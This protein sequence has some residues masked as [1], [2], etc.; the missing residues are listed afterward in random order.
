M[1]RWLVVGAGSAGC[2]VA[3]I[4][5]GHADVVL[6]EAGPDHG[7]D[8]TPD[9]GGP[10][11]DDPVRLRPDVM[12]RRR[13]GRTVEP[14]AQGFGIGGSGLVNGAIAVPGGPETGETRGHLLP[15][16]APRGRGR[17]AD[18]LRRATPDA[19]ELL[20]VR[21]DGRRVTTA[22]VYLDPVRD[23]VDVRARTSVERVLLDDG[24]AIGVAT[25]TG[26][27]IEADVVVVCSGAI[28]TPAL[29]LRSGVRTA[30]VGEGLQDQPAV[31]VTV[32][33]T[34]P[35]SPSDST[36]SVAVERTG[37]EILALERLTAGDG[38]GALM[39]GVTVV[40]ASGSV[41]VV[42]G[43]TQVDLGQLTEPVDVDR[44]LRATREAIELCRSPELGEV[45]AGA[46]LDD[47]GTPI[48]VVADDA[49]L[50]AWILDHH[51]GY[52]HVAGSCRMGVVTDRRGWVRGHHGLAIAD[53]SLL[54]GVP[55]RNLH[56]AVVAQA[57]RL[58]R[59]W[60][61]RIDG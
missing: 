6:L 59:E 47:A 50:R 34:E 28:G 17:L 48:D 19:V 43:E 36:L 16:E 46:Y 8:A 56:L 31:F 57:D 10:R 7:R 1:S 45:V 49:D 29:L 24:R 5:A 21:R 25:A 12:V 44:L 32:E 58:G 15:L 53:A 35:A 55:E 2:V 41:T 23:R 37:R 18:A 54:T 33:R 39:A 13:P 9:D 52:H 42:D 60:A 14:Y 27:E 22:D 40:A 11:L 38:F 61:A 4:L 3:G 20:H 30:G 51:L 26:E